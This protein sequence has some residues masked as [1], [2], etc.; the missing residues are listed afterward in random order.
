MFDK[1]MSYTDACPVLYQILLKGTMHGNCPIIMNKPI[2]TGRAGE[3]Y[4]K[5]YR[6]EAFREDYQLAQ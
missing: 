2:T 6:Y 5:G 1:V 4:I 3:Y